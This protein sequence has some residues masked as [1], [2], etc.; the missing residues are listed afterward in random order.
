MKVEID[1]IK[2]YTRKDGRNCKVIRLAWVEEYRGFGTIDIIQVDGRGFKIDSELMSREF[3]KRAL[4]ALVDQSEFD[5]E[6]NL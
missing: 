4:C 1:G 6:D 3:V 2:D 5:C